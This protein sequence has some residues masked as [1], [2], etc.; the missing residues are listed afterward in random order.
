MIRKSTLKY[1]LSVKSNMLN[2]KQVHMLVIILYC[3]LLRFKL[4]NKEL[5]GEFELVELRTY[6]ILSSIYGKFPNCLN[7]CLNCSYHGIHLR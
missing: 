1:I 7:F 6:I 2:Q 5:T 3:N 4:R